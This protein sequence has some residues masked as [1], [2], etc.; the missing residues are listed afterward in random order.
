MPNEADTTPIQERYAT[1]FATDLERIK[2]EREALQ[3]RLQQLDKEHGWLTS[4]LGATPAPEQDAAGPVERADS[5]ET[6]AKAFPQ[7][8]HAKKMVTGRKRGPALHE[9][10]QGLLSSEPRTVGE[11]TMGLES[12]YPEKAGTKAQL[13]RNALETL[14][15]RSRAERTKQGATV[16]YTANDTA[17]GA[18]R[19]VGGD[20]IRTAEKD[21]A[22][23]G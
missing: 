22:T 13:V 20:A 9:L 3:E 4:V 11:L 19:G 18:G 15:A 14:V 7:P 2:E 10:V 8:R 21:I 1:Q 5:G 23:A 16:Y 12:A 6:A 17:A